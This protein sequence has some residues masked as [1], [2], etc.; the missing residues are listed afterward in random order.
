MFYFIQVVILYDELQICPRIN[1]F[2]CSFSLCLTSKMHYKNGRL[3]CESIFIHI[4]KLIILINNIIGTI[5]YLDEK[6]RKWNRKDVR[7]YLEIQQKLSTTKSH[8]LPPLKVY[9]LDDMLAL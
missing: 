6:P 7:N 4:N 2:Y 1:D 3:Y 8:N 9:T 5:F